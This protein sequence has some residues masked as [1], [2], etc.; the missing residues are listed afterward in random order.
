MPPSFATGRL[1]HGQDT[2]F[3]LREIFS[4]T[5]APVDADAILATKG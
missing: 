1:D 5:T 4:P 2:D 3:R